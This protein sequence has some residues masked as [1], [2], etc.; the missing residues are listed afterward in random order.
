M[1]ENNYKEKLLLRGVAKD[2]VSYSTLTDIVSPNIGL[3][4][5]FD[6]KISI[7]PYFSKV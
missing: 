2:G 1:K 3:V 4:A 6:T 7:L 5:A